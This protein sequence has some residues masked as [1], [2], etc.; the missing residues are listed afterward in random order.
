MSQNINF[1]HRRGFGIYEEYARWRGNVHET[2]MQKRQL[3]A[4]ATER[5]KDRQAMKEQARIAAEASIRVAEEERM[6]REAQFLSN[7]KIAA[8][9]SE[10]NV[11]ISKKHDEIQR[12][13]EAAH[14]KANIEI[15]EINYRAERDR[16]LGR[17]QLKYDTEDRHK[18]E[19]EEEERQGGFVRDFN[20]NRI[21][22]VYQGEYLRIVPH[23]Q[24]D[25]YYDDNRHY[26]GQFAAG[27]FEG[28][29]KW[30]DENGTLVYSGHWAG[31]RFNGFGRLRINDNSFFVGIFR[32]G[33][34][35]RG[36]FTNSFDT[37]IPEDNKDFS[38]FHLKDDFATEREE[39]SYEGE[40][41]GTIPHGRGRKLYAN[42]DYDDG[43]FVDG[44][45]EGLLVRCRNG[46]IYMGPVEHDKPKGEGQ[47]TLPDGS[48]YVG[49]FVN[50]L[51][52]G[53]GYLTQEDGTLFE[54]EWSQKGET[55][56]LNGT[57][58]F[59][60]GR[61]LEGK[62]ED[63]QLVG[64]GIC[65]YPNGYVY[66]GTFTNNKPL[67]GKAKQ[68]FSGG[69]NVTIIIERGRVKRNITTYPDGATFTGSWCNGEWKN[70]T[71]RLPDGS[72]YSGEFLH[73]K[74]HGFGIMVYPDG[75]EHEGQW[76]NDKRVT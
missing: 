11:Q 51:V 59:K 37:D 68:D 7:E 19:A 22:G 21:P 56:I 60:D 73:F 47:I 41:K 64:T 74:R 31:G 66:Q 30:Y 18:R 17:L 34:F 35:Y 10:A 12:E 55:L 16:G 38:A 45:A 53:E 75:T 76:Q 25:F 40:M 3:K 67:D 26:I 15:A 43:V 27:R 44:K 23:G 29:G 65:T 61:I 58:K 52:Q 4:S 62:F 49:M 2:E 32:A 6:I 70:G 1:T 33:E 14:D 5:E 8:I 39:Y 57:A 46:R 71:L 69:I 24:G 54:G 50:G 9:Q 48:M 28:E 36:V 42:G 63:Q 13:I 20:G 72:Y